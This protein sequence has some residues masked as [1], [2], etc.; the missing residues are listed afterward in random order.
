M[1]R[2]PVVLAPETVNHITQHA[3]DSEVFAR[4][5]LD[6][7]AAVAILRKTVGRY[8]LELLD[9]CVL[10]NHLHLLLTAPKGNLPR[11]M[12]YFGAR[13][14]ERFNRRY[15]RRGHLVQ[16]PYF[17]EAV[18][19]DA[20]ALWVR[21]YIALNPVWAGMCRRPEEYL[22]SGYGGRGQLVP[23]PNR[24]TRQLVQAALRDGLRPRSR[25]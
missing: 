24:D 14:V 5:S 6:R 1:P 22:W 4:D 2:S 17:A 13:L 23:G 11:A 10:S 16:A 25:R 15:D 19:E 3:T 9:Y 8:E 7:D 18:L 20:H 12:Q 21:A